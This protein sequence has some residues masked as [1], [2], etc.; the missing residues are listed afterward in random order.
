MFFKGEII[1]KYNHQIL[2]VRLNKRLKTVQVKVRVK[3][4]GLKRLGS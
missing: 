1:V 3:V 4:L 2:N